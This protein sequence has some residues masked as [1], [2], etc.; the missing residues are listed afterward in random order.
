MSLAARL[1]A[2]LAR[3]LALLPSKP[4]QSAAGSLGW[5]G[6]TMAGGLRLSWKNGSLGSDLYVKII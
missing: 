4:P 1:W 3:A 6:M 2:P 5:E